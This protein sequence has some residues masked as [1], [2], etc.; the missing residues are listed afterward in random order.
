M[1]LAPLSE[2]ETENT[3]PNNLISWLGHP[4]FLGGNSAA[5][6]SPALRKV[7]EGSSHFPRQLTFAQ[8]FPSIFHTVSPL[9]FKTSQ[10]S[11]YYLPL[12]QVR[13]QRE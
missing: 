13:S 2:E 4:H 5:L 8:Y 7:R 1:L 12:A 11:R 3:C 6:P 9:F 10:E